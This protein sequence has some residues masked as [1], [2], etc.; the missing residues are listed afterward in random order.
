ME[1][2]LK[3]FLF[4]LKDNTM[5]MVEAAIGL[6]LIWILQGIVFSSVKKVARKALELSPHSLTAK[7]DVILL[8]PLKILFLSMMAYYILSIAA[9]KLSLDN[10]ATA[11]R[12]FV[13]ASVILCMAWTSMRWKKELLLG[14]KYHPKMI[15][16]GMSH[17]IGKILAMLIFILT[18]LILL[19]IFHV[20]IWPLLAF[21]GIGAAAVGFAAKDVIS[22]F[23]GGLMLSITRPFYVGEQ[24]L[25]PS[26]SLEGP[27]EEIG[28][29]LTVI[30]DK[31]K[32]AV[33]LP[34]AIFSSALVINA[35][36]MTHRRILE[37]LIFR[38]A[39]FDK[40]AELTKKLREYLVAH[41]SVD[42]SIDPLVYLS[43]FKEASLGVSLDVYVKETSL[44]D[45]MAVKEHILIGVYEVVEKMGAKMPCTTFAIEMS[46]S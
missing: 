36:R 24:I 2:G 37:Q 19:Q 38:F 42:T 41:P 40:I 17:T 44:K 13:H 22:N 32:R 10:V 16:M 11:V 39:D 26:L 15:S 29:Y 1:E 21:G 30:R 14:L 27:V 28:W 18:M 8:S 25:L 12:P 9:S 35:A 23:C 20:D 33:Y 31:D 6:G 34:N 46:T 7:I 43:T 3:T 4:F 5:W 45:Y